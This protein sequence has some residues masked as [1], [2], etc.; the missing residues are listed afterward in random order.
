MSSSA[1]EPPA[2]APPGDKLQKVLAAH[3]LGSRRTMEAW[4]TQGRVT[5]NGEKAHLG[6]RVSERDRIQVDGGRP[7]RQRQDHV[8]VLL[9]NK[10]A[11]T[12]C[13]RSDPE[14]RTTV[15]KGLPRLK[16]GRWITVGRLDIQTTGLLLLTNSGELANCMMHPSSG[17]DR[18]YAV[19][20]N[21]KLSEDALAELASGV[22][23][24]GELHRFSD[25]RYFNGRGT[26]HWYHVVLM[27]GKNR[28]VRR[29]FESL[30]LMVSRLKRVR[31]GP[32]LLP[33]W[34]PV[35]HRDELIESDVAALGQL[36]QV[37]VGRPARERAAR[38]EKSPRKQRSVLIEYPGLKLPA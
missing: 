36:L 32:V 9:L 12:V 7:L 23:I 15:F 6:Q 11:G 10:P 18:E 4:I 26:N 37:N 24:E 28:E 14:G 29:L 27:E 33:S 16:Q 25:I 31:Y 8:R 22:M 35:G 1:P 38:A 20:V 3:G 13:S 19:R 21:G 30:G 34:L 17:L 5:V 2:A